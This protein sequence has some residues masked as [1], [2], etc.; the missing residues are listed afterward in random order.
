[1]REKVAAARDQGH[2][3]DYLSFVPDGEPT[4]DENLGATIG[5][6]R[7][8]GI[9][10]AVITNGSLLDREDVRADLARADWVSLKVDTAH[11][12]TWRRINRPHRGLR[13]GRLLDGM[14]AFAATFNGVLTTETMI[15]NGLND[16]EVELRATASFASELSPAACYLAVPTRPPAESWVRPPAEPVIAR[17]YEVFRARNRCVELLV[18]LEDETFASTGDPRQDL[19]S[20]V[21]VHPMREAAVRRL[22][23]RAGAGWGLVREL[24]EQ[25]HLV[26]VEYGANH[27]FVRP[28]A[29]TAPRE[30][31]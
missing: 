6:L 20:I 4:L 21:A 27:Y 30:E 17:A 26:E 14:R 29:T 19:L 31:A 13:L 10:V 8:L 24:I 28:I 2:L 22:L 16:D 7:T 9:P 11:E 1:V 3:V 25:G 15:L 18:G 23:A 12:R 5:S